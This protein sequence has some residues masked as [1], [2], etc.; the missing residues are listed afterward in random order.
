MHQSSP[1]PET[2]DPQGFFTLL[3]HILSGKVL[4]A[5]VGS[6]LR[7]DDQAGLV[8]CDKLVERGIACIKCEYGLENCISEI[9]N[10]EVEKLVIVD[11]VIYR[12]ARPGEIVIASEDSL[13][14]KYSLATTHTMP[15]GLLSRMIHDA[16]IKEVYVVGVVPLNL[17]YGVEISSEVAESIEKLV[18]AFSMFLLE[19][20]KR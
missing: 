17:D 9:L 19:R 11:A 2:V 12:G 5:G 1:R 6:P 18:N 13:A 10:A 4:V 20:G 15:F 8:F 14:E 16:G 3:K 7:M